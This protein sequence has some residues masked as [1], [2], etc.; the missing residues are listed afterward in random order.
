MKTVGK[1]EDGRLG[2]GWERGGERER[3]REWQ[4]RTQQLSLSLL[5]LIF[6]SHYP[7]LSV[8]CVWMGFWSVWV[9]FGRCGMGDEKLDVGVVRDFWDV[10]DSF[11][12][13]F[14]FSSSAEYL[15]QSWTDCFVVLWGYFLSAELKMGGTVLSL[16]C[17]CNGSFNLKWE[18]GETPSASSRPTLPLALLRNMNN[19]PGPNCLLFSWLA[20]RKSQSLEKI[21]NDKC[22]LLQAWKFFYLLVSSQGVELRTICV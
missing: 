11:M 2:S 8:C 16:S 18:E 5:L 9:L 14:S 15:S 20:C 21:A 6:L 3:E 12:F 13:A 10:D 19:N 7:S 4:W 22:L 17:L 1:E